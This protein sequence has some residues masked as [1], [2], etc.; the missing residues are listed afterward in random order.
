MSEKGRYCYDYPRPGLTADAVVIGYDG[1]RLKVLLIERTWGMFK[2]MRALPGGFLEPYEMA[3]AAVKRE[4]EEETA[5]KLDR[6]IQIKTFTD[7]KRDPEVY[8][9]TVGFLALARIGEHAPQGGDDAANAAWIDL[10]KTPKLAFD[11]GE[12][13]DAAKRKLRAMAASGVAGLDLLPV[14]FTL[15]DLHALH[16]RIFRRKLEKR[17]FGREFIKQGL[18]KPAD[19][20]K[21]YRFNQKIYRKVLEEGTV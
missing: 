5:V 21:L 6:F 11:H 3:E 14:K 10:D 2:G 12:I 17:G 18:L 9:V 8:C 16:E 7:P 4:L 20:G 15:A 19:G 13:L 1:E